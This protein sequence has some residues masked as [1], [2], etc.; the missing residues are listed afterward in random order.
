MGST[1]YD[2]RA[3]LP[4]NWLGKNLLEEVLEKMGQESEGVML[5]DCFAGNKKLRAFYES[6]GFVLLREVPEEDYL[7]AVFTYK[8]RQKN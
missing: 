2:D 6:V 4:G 1:C 8:L 7:V 3:R 5:L